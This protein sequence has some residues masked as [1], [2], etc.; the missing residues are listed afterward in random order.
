MQRQ[1]GLDLASTRI[2]SVVQ[3]LAAW[4]ENPTVGLTISDRWNELFT[5]LPFS[6]WA[7]FWNIDHVKERLSQQV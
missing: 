1:Q 6:I 7:L 5:P 3:L 2:V 4:F